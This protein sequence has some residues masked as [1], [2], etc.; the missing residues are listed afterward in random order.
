MVKD[1]EFSSASRADKKAL[2]GVLEVDIT[3]PVITPTSSTDETSPEQFSSIDPEGND[4]N[5]ITFS[6]SSRTEELD[7]PPSNAHLIKHQSVFTEASPTDATFPSMPL[8]NFFANQISVNENALF[9]DFF[10]GHDC[11]SPIEANV[12]THIVH[13]PRTPTPPSHSTVTWY[14]TYHRR[15]VNSWQYYTYYDYNQ[16]HTKVLFAMAEG[17][18]A[19]KFG[20]AAFSALLYSIRYD[21]AVKTFAFWF[22]SRAL[23]EMAMLIKK[24]YLDAVDTQMAIASAM[25]LSTFD[26]TSVVYPLMIA[27]SRR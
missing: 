19:L 5:P 7:R 17:C 22:Y 11:P 6:T 26:V 23:Q 13:I 21:P 20:M 8:S 18:E 2:E 25:Q 27:T 3:T 12:Y 16:L 4:Y 15:T 14:L 10:A 24:P 1:D 9:N